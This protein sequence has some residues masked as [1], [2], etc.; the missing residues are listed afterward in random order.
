MT[1]SEAMSL[2]GAAVSRNMGNI[3]IELLPFLSFFGITHPTT[4]HALTYSQESHLQNGLESLR[5]K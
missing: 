1:L 2:S 4:A 5:G 3:D